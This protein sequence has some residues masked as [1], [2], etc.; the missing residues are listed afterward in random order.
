MNTVWI[1]GD[2]YT[3]EAA[4]LDDATRAMNV[5]ASDPE[6]GHVVRRMQTR[7]LYTESATDQLSGD[8]AFGAYV[9]SNG[10]LRLNVGKVL[11]WRTA[12]G[13]GY[14][15]IV[16]LLV[17]SSHFGGAYNSMANVAYVAAN[18]VHFAEMLRHE[19]L[20]HAIGGLG[21]EYGRSGVYTGGGPSSPNLDTENDPAR[22]KWSH[23]IGRDDGMGGTVGVFEGGGG[24]Y[25]R[26]IYRP[27]ATSRMRQLGKPW[28]PVNAE[29]IMLAAARFIP[30]IEGDLNGD[31]RVDFDD[32][33]LALSGDDFATTNEVLSNFGRSE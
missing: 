30:R 31:G 14:H 33:N 4:F 27:T 25:S 2:G 7:T 19:F 5:L 1:T 26:G 17:N 24:D 12:K 21:D 9:H 13:V 16:L 6:V 18:N 15:D 3:D 11:S 32:L 10:N 28:G 23:L 29:A 8:T 20:G 22:V